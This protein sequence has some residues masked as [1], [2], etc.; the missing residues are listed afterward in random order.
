MSVQLYLARR[1][2]ALGG[3]AILAL[4]I[5]TLLAAAE[6]ARAQ[7]QQTQPVQQ[8]QASPN[9]SPQSPAPVAPV[10]A[11]PPTPATAAPPATPAPSTPQQVQS[12]P[13]A[14]G[15]VTLPPLNVVTSRV[16]PQP[17]REPA[18]HVATP[19]A[20][21]GVPQVTAAEQLA[22]QNQSFDQ[23][24]SNLFTT[25]GTTSAT[26]SRENIQS[27]PQGTDQPVEKV[28][29]QFPGVSQDSASSGDLHIRNDHA[30]AQVRINGI[31]MPDGVTGFSSFLD[32]S[33]IGSLSLVTGALPAEYGLRTTGLIDITTRT[34]IFNNSGSISVY[35]GSRSMITPSVEYGGTFG[36]N[37][38]SGTPAS[39]SSSCYGGVQYFFTGRYLQ[40]QEGIENPLPTLNA[41]HDFS[42]QA[43]G[44]AYLSTF[45]D[46]WTRLTMMM[47]TS[48][49]SYQI[50]NVT[51]APLSSLGTALPSGPTS[52]NSAGLN[53][54]QDEDTQFGV[55]A[56]QRSANGFD[57]QLSYFTRYDNLHFMP[58]PTGDLL[59]NGIASDVSRQAYT[60]GVQGDASYVVT[61]AHTIRVGF[62]VSGEKTWV[63][64]T[65]IVEP[66]T[67]CDGTDT[68]PTPL[69][70]TD[71]N[72][73]VGWLAGIYAQDE[74]KITN[75]L[76]MNYGARF[77]QMW[78][79]TNAN[80]LSPR[81]S[82]TYKPFE[83][84]T[85]H[86]GYAR[87]FTPPV[88]VEAA[89]ANIALFNGT[90]G[91]VTNP[92]GSNPVL[93]E[94]SHY[95]DA[96]IDQVI[97]LG[98]WSTLK[99]DCATLDIGIDGYYKI[100]SD[101]L[102]NGQFGQALVLDAFNYAHG[103]AE[104]VELSAKYH[105]GGFDGYLNVA[106]SQEKATQPVSNQFLFDNTTP[107]ADLGG[108]TEFQYVNS[109]WIF[110]DHNQFV[111]GSAGASYQFCGR[112]LT[113]AELWWNSV[114]GTKISADM[115]YG[116]GLRN[117]DANIS[118]ER[119]YEQIN[120]G[121]ARDFWMPDNKPL[122]LRF[123]VV[124]LADEIYQIR[125]GSGI[126]VF[127][128]QFGPRRGYFFGISKKL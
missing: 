71:D 40:T 5:L 73:K 91:Q 127:A 74:W 72:A 68:L 99:R 10:P 110:T 121:I 56:L 86:A 80:Q 87:Y 34:D 112:T 83:N 100:A 79:Y 30:N 22:T 117:G 33:W 3:V 55:L 59:L 90:T 95:F 36:A 66:C 75:N 103:M 14:P 67:A 60:N 61:P 116:S 94:R 32:P 122:T 20:S 7:D 126:G 98:C 48:T 77:D 93:P 15:N 19:A 124:N 104:G 16:K 6:A 85:F 78:Q 107:L 120:V 45:V 29:L 43:K 108:L 70:I 44:F 111:T 88:Q 13:A 106:V 49:N 23:A 4:A 47:G 69:S 64:N 82:F 128:A 101:L 81:V 21:S 37:C 18:Q 76:T 89:P 125:D 11:A 27:L 123:D 84:T 52:F 28:L 8:A 115:I 25:A 17:R 97:P 96:G 92:A 113:P 41:I 119:P 42:T 46:P 26:F 2:T 51:N 102:D 1:A 38:P 58:D 62:T 105:N 54:R 35:G 31:M 53:E 9:E 118:S 12:A 109:H 65:S 50:P 63:D 114:C 39:K 24:R 57:G